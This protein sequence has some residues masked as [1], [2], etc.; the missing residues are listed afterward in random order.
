MC[1]KLL[2]PTS[3]CTTF[4]RRDTLQRMLDEHVQGTHDHKRGHQTDDT[5]CADKYEE[6]SDGDGG[7]AAPCL[8]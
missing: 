6:P 8:F 2:G 4:F 3:A 5:E 7:L 1:G